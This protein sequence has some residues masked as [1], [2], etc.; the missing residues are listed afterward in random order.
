MGGGEWHGFRLFG[1]NPPTF[2]AAR[3]S[4]VPVALRRWILGGR[5]S[6]YWYGDREMSYNPNRRRGGGGRGI[7]KGVFGVLGTLA[8]VGLLIL[9]I[10]VILLVAFWDDAVRIVEDLLNLSNLAEGE[11]GE[12]GGENGGGDGD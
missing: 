6:T 11:G 1:R 5:R 10:L 2:S 4:P 9:L 7:A 3:A 12:G 8:V